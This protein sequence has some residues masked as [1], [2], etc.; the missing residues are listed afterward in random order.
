M[1]LEDKKTEMIN[2]LNPFINYAEKA[3]LSGTLKKNV[4]KH[5]TNK[6]FPLIL[7]E[8]IMEL[9]VFRAEKLSKY[10]MK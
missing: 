8:Q 7:A 9:G 2:K 6:N 5:F 4:V 10:K 1:T 3:L